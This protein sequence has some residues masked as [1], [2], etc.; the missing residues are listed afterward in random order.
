ML[1]L[2]K[3]LVSAYLEFSEKC[4]C[5]NCVDCLYADT[6]LPQCEALLLADFLMNSDMFT[7]PTTPGPSEADPNMMELCFKNGEQH[8]RDK[9]RT[10][11]KNIS[12][13]IPCIPISQ[14][15]KIMEDL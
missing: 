5:E 11:L 4:K 14:V 13:D 9:I 15:I 1:D 2:K 6:P 10:S 7:K 12:A 8:M 3:K